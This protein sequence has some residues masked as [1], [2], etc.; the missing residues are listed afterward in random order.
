MAIKAKCGN[1]GTGFKAKDAL[2]GR[3]V[4]CPKCANPI[5]IPAA[6]TN[7]KSPAKKKANVRSKQTAGASSSVANPML[8]LLRDA[9][10]QSMPQG[11]VCTSCGSEMGATAI[12]CVECGFNSETGQRLTTEASLDTG[13]EMEYGGQT[14]AESLIAKADRE[15]D[16][17]EI[18]DIDPDF[19]DGADSMIIAGVA[20][21]VMLVLVGTG[22][23]IVF[24]MDKLAG[25]ISPAVI[26][27]WAAVIIGLVCFCWIVIVGFMTSPKHG[28]LS[29]VSVGFYGFANKALLIPTA[30]WAMCIVIA[31]ISAG[32]MSLNAKEPWEAMLQVGSYLC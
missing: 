14:S 31:G 5:K 18:S 6:G 8:D 21:L 20:A 25:D 23:A 3:S 22:L 19:G 9:G 24:L 13:D 10:V 28:V 2:A 4:K 26:S 27:F 29:L 12:I 7:P 16:E 32:I 30:V 15:L 1:C 17:S 11:P